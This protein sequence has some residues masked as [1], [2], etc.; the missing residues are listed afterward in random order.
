MSRHSSFHWR[1]VVSFVQPSL[2]RRTGFTL[3]ELLVVIAIIAM[4]AGLL[5]PAVNSARESGR[6]TQC[7]NNQR[8]FGQAVQ[9]HVTSKDS[10][11]GYRQVMTRADG[12]RIAI[13]WQV[14]LMP[15]LG[16]SDVYEAL[17]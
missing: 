9:Q 6:Q 2:R 3:V 11:P 13:N 12:S 4:L 7:M 16:K 5:L 15:N 1:L 8:N 10:F 17:K 14:A